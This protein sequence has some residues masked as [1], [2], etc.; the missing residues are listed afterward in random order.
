VALVRAELNAFRIAYRQRVGLLHEQLEQLELEIAEA[1]LGELSREVESGRGS[2]LRQAPPSGPSL[3]R[4]TRRTP[5]AG[6]F[7]TSRR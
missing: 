2:P 1:E 5:S 4:D 3:R 6:Y 7:A